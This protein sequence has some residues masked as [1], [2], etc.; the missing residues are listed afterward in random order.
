MPLVINNLKQIEIAKPLWAADRAATNEVTVL[1]SDLMEYLLSHPGSTGLVDSVD[2]EV[3]RPN[4]IGTPAE[5]QLEERHW[6][7]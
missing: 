3:Y 4:A 7:R 6:Q 2:G 5:T 1:E